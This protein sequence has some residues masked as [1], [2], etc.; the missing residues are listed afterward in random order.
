LIF[1]AGL[2]VFSVPAL[3]GEAFGLYLI[4]ALA[5]GVPVVQPRHAAFP[6]LVTATGG[7]LLANRATQNRWPTRLKSLFLNPDQ[8]GALAQAGQTAVRERSPP[9]AMAQGNL[10]RF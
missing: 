7:G 10:A 6:E 8:A 1:C 5:A 4:E 3:Y 9:Q 2:T